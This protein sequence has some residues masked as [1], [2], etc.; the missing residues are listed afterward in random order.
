M[1]LTN[2]EQ[3]NLSHRLY[4]ALVLP[5]KDDEIDESGLRKLVRYYAEHRF[6]K[7]GGLI[8]NPEAGEVS[9]LSRAEKRR[10]LKIVMEEA[11]GRLPVLA[12]TFGWTTKDAV[13][14]AKDAKE[15][16]VDGIFVIPPA[17]SM[18]VSVAWDAARYPEVWQ[19]LVIF[20]SCHCHSR[21]FFSVLSGTHAS[22][23]HR[24]P[25]GLERSFLC[26]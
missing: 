10:V 7:V 1:N 25:H 21:T 9:Y 5:L 20:V 13:E 16:G 22:I 24:V 26:A 11:G 19:S 12:G 8:A 2:I 4:T 6:S 3:R 18:D 17:G 15:H 14:A 23:L